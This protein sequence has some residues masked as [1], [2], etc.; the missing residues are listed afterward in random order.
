MGRQRALAL[1]ETQPAT[2]HWD[3]FKEMLTAE[4][5]AAANT[6][7]AYRRDLMAIEAALAGSCDLADATSE[8]LRA[9]F[10]AAARQVLKPATAA[11]RLSA[12]RQFFRFLVAEGR[13][14]DDPSAALDAP[15]R[16]RPLPKVLSEAEV[17]AMIDCVARQDKAAALRLHAL[18]ELLYAT[19]LRVSELVGLPLAAALR[20]QPYLV[21]RGKGAKERLVPLNPAAKAAVAAYLAVRAK[22]LP[23]SLKASPWLFPSSGASGH[24]TRQR[25]G[26]LLKDAAIAAGI[27]P[28]RVSP[29]VLRHAFATHLLDHGADLRALQKMLGHADIATTQIYTHVA[30]GRLAELVGRA[31]PL[32]QQAGRPR[33]ARPRKD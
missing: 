9:C 29:H 5:N 21:V 2:R 20:D 4:R 16:G 24:L 22:F 18:L 7:D 27:A 31:H 17:A 10:A 15:K 32:S 33:P 8:Q 12:L 11:R 26:Q 23:R 28:E 3:V 30:T 1:D 13:R 19:G 6:V 14:A 25:F